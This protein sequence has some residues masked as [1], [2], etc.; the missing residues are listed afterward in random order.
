[1]CV[2]LAVN[3]RINSLPKKNCGLTGPDRNPIG[4]LVQPVGRPTLGRAVWTFAG[5]RLSCAAPYVRASRDPGRAPARRARRRPAPR[6]DARPSS[7]RSLAELARLAQDARARG[8]RRAVTQR[9]DAFDPGAVLGTGK[10]RGAARSSSRAATPSTSSLVDHE[11]SP[12]QARNLEKA[13]G[14]EV[15]DRT[16]VI[17][18][19]FHRHARSRAAKAQVEIVRLQYLAPR[20]REPGKGQGSPARR[21]RR[22]GRG[23]VEPGARPPQDPRS[24][25]RADARARRAGRGAAH[26][27]RPPPRHEPRRAG[28]LHQRRQV[29]AD[30]RA[31]RQRGLRRR[32]AVRDARHHGARRCVPA[33][34]AARAGL[35][36][37]SASSRS[38]RTAWSRRSRARSTRRW[39]RACSLH[40]VDASDPD[41]ERQLAV[42]D[43]VL[44]E[45]GAGD[46]P[47]LLVFNKIDRVGAPRR[48]GRP[49]AARALARAR[50]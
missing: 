12:S 26:A 36:T 47:R 31:D 33:T 46:V 42:T 18:E 30:A 39:R 13:T 5:E 37:P 25:R 27:A 40:V 22:Q 49:R 19:I 28:R 11:L 23:R 48:G 38:C 24:H 32:Q 16:A 6:R 1:M 34:R 41:F 8:R 15:L 3:I 17:L 45:I 29:D 21:H 9:R 20:L 44:A 7:P 10:L 2:N 14:V 43:E 50:S 35:A 4:R